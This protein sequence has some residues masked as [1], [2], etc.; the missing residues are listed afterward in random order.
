MEAQNVEWRAGDEEEDSHRRCLINRAISE[1][2]ATCRQSND[3]DGMLMEKKCKKRNYSQVEMSS[4]KQFP[5]FD[6][7]R[8]KHH[9]HSFWLYT[10]KKSRWSSSGVHSQNRKQTAQ[11]ARRVLFFLLSSARLNK[12]SHPCAWQRRVSFAY[13]I[14]FWNL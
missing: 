4:R 14:S 9:T 12:W 5:L 3:G 6:R 11:I 13:E 8:S 1:I 10:E 7:S 2:K